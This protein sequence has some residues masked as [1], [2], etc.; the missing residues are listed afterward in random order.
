[1]SVLQC[2]QLSNSSFEHKTFD[3]LVQSLSGLSR[4]SFLALQDCELKDGHLMR[5]ACEIECM[6]ALRQLDLAGAKFGIDSWVVLTPAHDRAPDMFQLI[7][8]EI[9]MLEHSFPEAM[10][11]VELAQ[12]LHGPTHRAWESVL[13]LTSWVIDQ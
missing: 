6:L 5:L 11:Y 13:L 2:L 9:D 10:H 3:T 8:D 1:M 7:V 4:S 12:P